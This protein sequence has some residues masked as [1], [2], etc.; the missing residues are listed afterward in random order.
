MTEHTGEPADRYARAR[1]EEEPGAHSGSESQA[2]ER[3]VPGT[4]SAKEGYQPE[5]GTVAGEPLR[6]VGMED[7]EDEGRRGGEDTGSGG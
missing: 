2:R 3:T 6:G 1:D 7:Q 4:A 5:A